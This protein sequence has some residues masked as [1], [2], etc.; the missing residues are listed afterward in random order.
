MRSIYCFYYFLI[1]SLSI[2]TYSQEHLKTVAN[3]FLHENGQFHNLHQEKFFLHTNKSIYFSGEKVWFKTYVV[4]DITDT[5]YY[6]T[7][8]LYVNLYN[9]ERKL[10][11]HQLFY[12]EDGVSHGEI[13][14]SNKL[15]SGEY[16]IELDTQWNKNFNNKNV[17]P[18]QVINL[19]DKKEETPKL[20]S[21][22]V[23]TGFDI[24]FY[25]ESNVLLGNFEN[26]IYFTTKNNDKPI[27]I[28]GK[29]I[30]LQTGREVS[31]ILSNKSGMGLF[32][33][34]Y[35]AGRKYIVSVIVNGKKQ[36]FT[37]P[38]AKT[39]G[40]VIEK[41]NE[42]NDNKTI[43]FSVKTNSAT[44]KKHD[45]EIF[46]ATVH[47][48]GYLKSVV[49]IQLEKKY[50]NYTVNLILEN[51]F[52][53][54]NTITLFN[55]ENTPVSSRSFFCIKDKIIELDIAKSNETKDSITLDL[56][57]L[58]KYL[59]ANS[60]ISILPEKTKLYNSEF[61]ILTQFLIAPYINIDSKNL[62][63]FFDGKMTTNDIDM[64]LQTQKNIVSFPNK[65]LIK[66]TTKYKP[67]IGLTIKGTVDSA[68]IS[69]I[70]CKVL[71][72]SEENNILKYSRIEKDNSFFFDSLYFIHPS[73]YKLALIDSKGK[74]A[75][76]EF[77][78][79]NEFT[80]YKPNSLLNDNKRVST[81]FNLI[82]QKAEDL[83][84]L[85]PTEFEKL[86][87]VMLFGTKKKVV[88]VDT[89]TNY[90][91]N[92]KKL[93]NGST[94]KLKRNKIECM[95]CTLLKLLD[96]YGS[97]TAKVSGDGNIGVRFN[98]GI[99]T[100]LGTLDAL[101]IIDNKTIPEGALDVLLDIR[102]QDVESIKVNPSGAGYGVKGS[103]GTTVIIAIARA[104]H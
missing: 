92:T 48:N 44:L 80:T 52:N 89:I 39:T 47:R 30:D 99:N 72:S 56:K 2:S 55:Q 71:L 95:D 31:E 75:K 38:D 50:Y 64:L 33:L 100:F 5:P 27:S 13:E 68:L 60:S 4:Y 17:Y 7:Y 62:T 97:V 53:G 36:K 16:Y 45:S 54:L 76:G 32:K 14:L 22:S 12:V 102:A 96:N 42:Q 8:N 20:E 63:S 24:Q 28:N 57:M 70:N 35:L 41:K 43:S 84:F 90:P 10:I 101:V 74:I 26:T 21:Q 65:H 58:N 83:N 1:F 81:K 91:H 3:S 77:S 79:H 11:S 67:E 94:K 29:I 46:F 82:K 69:L 66:N 85:T 40:F 103:N 15:I 9:T 34:P 86:D 88:E 61:N 19:N 93:G 51:L 18:I 59:K 87:E 23:K 78:V 37:I 73:K 98:R 104:F 25:P 49:P 6:A